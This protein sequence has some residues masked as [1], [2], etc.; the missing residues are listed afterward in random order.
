MSEFD[1]VEQPFTAQKPASSGLGSKLW[2][3]LVAVLV[4]LGIG[5]LWWWA[6]KPAKLT[7]EDVPSQSIDEKET[8]TIP[9]KVKA[10]GL[11]EGKWTFGMVAGPPGAKVDPKSGVFTWKPTED[12]G[13]E[14]YDVTLGVKAIGDKPTHTKVS[15]KIAVREVNE[16]PV[17]PPVPPLTVGAGAVLRLVLAAKDAD[18][19]AQ[20]LSYRL[21]QAPDGAKLDAATGKFT[22]SPPESSSATEITVEAIV[23][24]A[25]KDGAETP[26]TFKIKVEPL[27]SPALRLAALLRAEGLTVEKLRGEAPAG[28]KG[29]AWEFDI[30]DEVLI[31]LEYD[32]AAA[33]K[34][35]AGQVSEDGQTL[36]GEKA[37]WTSKTRI[38]RQDRLIVLFDGT[39]DR[40]VKAVTGHLGEPFVV[41]EASKAE[42]I[43]E[44]PVEPTLLDKLVDQLAKLHEKKDLL[45]KPDYPGVRKLFSELFEQQNEFL[46]TRFY[47]GDGAELKKWLDQHN[48]FK[49]ELYTA[50][51]PEDDIP[52][53]LTLLK[54]LL[55][56]FPAKLDEYGQLAIATVVTWD[57]DR[58]TYD[59]VHHQRRTH[60]VLP[61]GM[62]GAVE[63]F[64]Y[65]VDA[66]RVMQGRAQFLPWEF[67]IYLINHKTPRPEREWAAA[68]Y[69]AKR[70]MFGKC[71][72]DVP[73]DTE[74]LKTESKI[75][76]LDGKDYTLLNLKE[77]GGVCAMQ[78]D[79]AARVGKSLGVPAEYVSGEA[80][81]G[82]LHAWV[83]W[84]EV[85]QVT[86]T[87]I[88]F[89]L[90]SHG[91]YFGDKYYV[92]KLRDP[93][94]GKGITDRDLELRLQAVG[95][96]PLSF[97]HAKLLMQV[98]PQLRDKLGW[99]PMQEIVFLNEIIEMCPGNEAAWQ[100]VAKLARDG[101]VTTESYRLVT[102]MFDKLFR[103]F[104]NFPDFTWQVFDDLV[105]YQKNDKQRNKFYERLVQM[106]EAGGRPDLA[107][108]ARLR[109]SDY[110]LEEGRSKDVIAGL[111]FTIKKFP[112]EGRYVPKLLDK[113]ERVCE[114]IKGADQQVLQFYQEFIPLI[115]PKRGNEPSEYCMKM[116]DR[117]VKKFTAAGQAQQAQVFA[118]QLAK[119]KASG[120]T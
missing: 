116:L 6:D 49:E 13:P 97:R 109:L 47:E 7:L 117:A 88:S 103:T 87:G 57:R 93:Q 92:G 111:A 31:V 54:T 1:F 34:E 69:V 52:A 3:G 19:P 115:P 72:A 94:T 66:E 98:Y 10:K 15:F 105:Q 55:E 95:L 65:F 120:G 61:D 71:Y 100:Q 113:L 70:T 42:P 17:V 112:E 22:W 77:L 60:S 64:Q 99:K 20:K 16:P 86:R 107:C 35:D 81:N 37:K 24:D 26:F 32:T 44:R 50:F 40:V 51:R 74:M 23:A 9:L 96:N 36:F 118:N 58:S 48:D 39:S 56:K 82:G 33:A 2:G 108:E 68:N 45:G 30:N 8:L 114:G 11:K 90:E 12:Q 59:Y 80:N 75:C 106:Y 73:Y 21:Q 63:N 76:K 102:A 119:L 25:E 79:F 101:R 43:P 67:Q 104:A 28:F 53:A 14:D 91:R 27:A 29:T 38:Y 41:A 46:L 18:K 89:T 84:V 62:L 78:A 4:V 83:M 5:G 110:L 85:K